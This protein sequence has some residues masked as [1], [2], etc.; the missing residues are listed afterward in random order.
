MI[1][2]GGITPTDGELCG[3]G[4]GTAETKDETQR[5]ECREDAAAGTSDPRTAILP[6]IHLH[7]HVHSIAPSAVLYFF[8][9]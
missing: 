2:R 3:I 1:A 6:P 8:P 5:D 7:V 9:Q 4:R